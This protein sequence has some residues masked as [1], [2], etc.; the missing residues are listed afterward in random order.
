MFWTSYWSQGVIV[1]YGQLSNLSA[2]SRRMQVNLQWDEDEVLT[3]WVGVGFIMKTFF[4][5]KL[6]RI[7]MS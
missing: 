6:Y 1:V 4:F 5:V 7:Y 2:I 3:R